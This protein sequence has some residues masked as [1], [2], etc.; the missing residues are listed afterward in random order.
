LEGK[1]SGNNNAKLPWLQVTEAQEDFVS[2]DY[3]PELFTLREPS[4]LKVPEKKS[5]LDFWRKR[6]DNPKKRHVFLWKAYHTSDGMVDSEYL[7]A[8]GKAVAKGK[9]GKSSGQPKSRR[10]KQPRKDKARVLSPCSDLEVTEVVKGKEGKSSGSAKPRPRR[11]PRKKEKERAISP[12]GDSED[13]EVDETGNSAEANDTHGWAT[14]GPVSQPSAAGTDSES[15][16]NDS[17]STHDTFNVAYDSS[18]RAPAQS[19]PSQATS[20]TALKKPRNTKTYGRDRLMDTVVNTKPVEHP[21]DDSDSAMHSDH[22]NLAS[23]HNLTKLSAPEDRQLPPANKSKR[24]KVQEMGVAVTDPITPRK[25]CRNGLGN[26]DNVDEQ[27]T[28]TTR[29][30]TPSNKRREM[31]A[32][33]TSQNPPA[34]KQRRLQ[35]PADDHVLTAKKIIRPAT[36]KKTMKPKV[37]EPSTPPPRPKPILKRKPAK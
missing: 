4:R 34:K 14:A 30:R 27:V 5:L 1:A 22:S 32:R 21:S 17:G 3:I 29:V 36:T 23:N 2:A 19:A 6:Q 37:A 24:S 33:E 35:Q 25:P 9:Q 7:I 26:A 10:G 31:E 8:A 11:Q 16:S 18:A 12:C 28:G 15:D 20:L 13:T